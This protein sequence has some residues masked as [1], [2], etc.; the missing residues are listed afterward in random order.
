MACW[1]KRSFLSVLLSYNKVLQVRKLPQKLYQLKCSRAG[2]CMVPDG[3]E[4][5]G[6]GDLESVSQQLGFCVLESLVKTSQFGKT[7]VRRA[8]L[9][10]SEFFSKRPHVSPNRNMWLPLTP[11]G[12]QIVS[13]DLLTSL[14]R[15]RKTCFSFGKITKSWE[16]GKVSNFFERLPDSSKQPAVTQLE[17]WHC[18]NGA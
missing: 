13:R 12:C 11:H 14:C 8:K 3:A 16:V 6:W 10:K 7:R 17:L 4:A 15:W 9:G 18:R 2:K 1:G 5:C